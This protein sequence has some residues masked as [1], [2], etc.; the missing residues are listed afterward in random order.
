MPGFLGP[1][2]ADSSFDE[3]LA[4]LLSGSRSGTPGRAV[5]I[6]RLLS[7]RTQEL[8]QQSGEF[9]AAHG[10]PGVDALHLLH[11]LLTGSPVSTLVERVGADPATLAA[12]IE[13][14]LP[15]S[16]GDGSASA[17]GL[18]PAAQR[19]L[20]LAAQIARASGSTFIDPEH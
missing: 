15:G 17:L 12:E 11:V 9:A 16:S 14:R 4:R 7:R 18:V 2:S 19:A 3:F 10:H 1:D 5:D 20:F 8:V 6:T 13:G